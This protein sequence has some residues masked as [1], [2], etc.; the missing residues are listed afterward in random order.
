MTKPSAA[1]DA[2]AVLALLRDEPAAERVQRA[3]AKG[4]VISWINLGEVLYIET[5]RLDAKR[6]GEAVSKVA[7][8]LRAE[9]PDEGAVRLA[10]RIKAGGRVSY[11]DCFAAA[12]AE[13]HGVPLLTGDPE[14]IGLKRPSLRITDLTV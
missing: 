14:L 9:P 5:R 7:D 12:T 3:V 11:A 6:A 2:W 10:A 4:A 13:R 8:T 1:L